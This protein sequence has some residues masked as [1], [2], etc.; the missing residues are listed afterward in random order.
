[1]SNIGYD[2]YLYDINVKYILKKDFES[3]SSQNIIGLRDLKK[4]GESAIHSSGIKPKVFLKDL[5]ASN[6]KYII[7]VMGK[8]K[9]QLI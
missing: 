4:M 9:L 6:D 8:C 2:K 1:M 7:D 3:D 5:A